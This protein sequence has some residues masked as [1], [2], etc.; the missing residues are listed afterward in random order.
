MQNLTPELKH[1]K[2]ATKFLILDPN[3]PRLITRDDDRHPEDDAV[4]RLDT[5]SDKM[6]DSR[7]KIDELISSIIQNG[8]LPVDA[9]FVK[10]LESDS[11]YYLVLEGNRRVT[12]LRSLL[13]DDS[14]TIELK[15]SIS[16]IDVMEIVDDI[17]IE[18]LNNKITY[19]LGVRHHG[20][21]KKWSPF[22]QAKNIYKRY[23]EISDIQ[24]E[25]FSWDEET[26]NKVADAL[27]INNDQ[28]KNRLKVFKVM[29]QLSQHPD[30]ID[31]PGGMKDRY[32]SV[33]AEIVLTKDSE[34][35]K[36]ISK[37]DVSFK[38]DDESLSKMNKLCHFDKVNREQSPI[39]NPQ[40]WRKLSAI[41]KDIDENKKVQM[42]ARVEVDKIKPSI[43]WAER[44]SELQTLHWDRWLFKVN[45]IIKRI[46]MSDD[47]SSDAAVDVTRKLTNILNELDLHDNDML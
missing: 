10:K 39:N 6:R 36:Y 27:S 26:G 33:C 44:A 23:L 28:V 46:T 18:E 24:P 35:N 20:A 1:I 31:S 42:L 4:S 25:D 14:I 34:L 47:L 19:L 16:E 43:V 8:W 5:T 38:L 11:K 30:I 9:I 7:F 2:V 40:E 21:L 32:Y 17:P 12:A 15:N 41:L 22:A 29:E 37:D 3:N 45:S 13:E